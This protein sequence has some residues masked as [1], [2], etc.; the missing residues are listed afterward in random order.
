MTTTKK[1]SR[2]KSPTRRSGKRT[3]LKFLITAGGTREY[4]DPVRFITNASSGKMGY[5]LARAAVKAGHSTT[6]ISTVPQMP[7]PAGVRV[8]YVQSAKEMFD[9]VKKYFGG[10]DCLIMAAAVADYTPAV[11]ATDKIKKTQRELVIRLKPTVDILKWAGEHKP[12]EKKTAGGTTV[13]RKI[14]VGFALEQKAIL[15]RAEVKLRE[16]NLDLIVANS[17]ST[18]GADT[19]SV[20]VNSAGRKWLKLG[21]AAK[22]VIAGRIVRLIEQLGGWQAS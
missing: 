6:L 20:W 13:Q 16:K 9:A 15:K 17:P 19:A 3:G 4:I 14:L 8:L 12:A 11:R 1:H 10:C 7:V 2:R 5:A 18:I 21:P 22:S